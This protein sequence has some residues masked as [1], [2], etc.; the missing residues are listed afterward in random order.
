MVKHL[1]LVQPQIRTLTHGKLRRRILHQ[2]F[3]QRP[4][5]FGH[6]LGP[7]NLQ[8][9]VIACELFII[10]VIRCS[11]QHLRVL[12]VASR[13]RKLPLVA[14][15]RVLPI[16]AHIVHR[17]VEFSIQGLQVSLHEIA[18]TIELVV[19]LAGLVAF[20]FEIDV[21]E[22]LFHLALEKELPIVVAF[23]KC[24]SNLAKVLLFRLL[25]L[26]HRLLND[27]EEVGCHQPQIVIDTS[28]EYFIKLMILPNLAID[29]QIQLV[30]NIVNA[31][32]Q[33][34]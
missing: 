11:V 33:F 12:P 3:S 24:F 13:L 22:H 28:L 5:P 8:A 14:E 25:D 16:I 4:G 32:L 7:E 15:A 34:I 1:D 31:R 2:I 27:A 6:R 20:L 26:D 18:R 19:L 10:I 30:L 23:V 29:E 9:G 21:F 17:P